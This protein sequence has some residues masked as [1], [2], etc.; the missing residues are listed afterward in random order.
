MSKNVEWVF[1]IPIR[2]ARRA[3]RSY[4]QKLVP[5]TA[6]SGAAPCSFLH[7]FLNATPRYFL[8]LAWLAKLRVAGYGPALLAFHRAV[9]QG[10]TA[11]ARPVSRSIFSRRPRSFRP[12]AVS[13]GAVAGRAGAVYGRRSPRTGGRSPLAGACGRT[14]G[15]SVRGCCAQAV[16][17]PT[18][19]S[20]RRSGRGPVRDRNRSRRQ[21]PS[22]RQE[23]SAPNSVR[24][25]P[26]TSP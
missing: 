11:L 26:A 6:V 4:P 16:Q 1:E 22:V 8:P 2:Q 24:R 20:F 23:P 18:A 14:V 19:S 10:R 17:G 12:G 13:L 9:R 3:G 15:T 5:S 7:P 25:Q 21:V